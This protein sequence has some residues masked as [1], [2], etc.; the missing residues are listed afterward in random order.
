M[1][2][3]V[4]R[5]SARQRSAAGVDGAGVHDERRDRSRRAVRRSGRSA[6]V[7]AVRID[8]ALE[9][10]RR[11]AI[12]A[13]A[14][15]RSARSPIGSNQAISSATVVVVVGDLGVG[16]AHHPGDADR[17]I[18]G[19][20]DQQVVGGSVRSTPSSVVIG[21]PS[22]RQADAEA[23]AAERGQVVGVVRLA[24]LEHHVVADVDD[25]VD[26]AHAGG[27]QAAR[28]PRRGD[29]PTATPDMTVRREAA[30]AVAVDDLDGERSVVAG[31]RGA[32]A[33]GRE[34][35]RRAGRRGRGRRRRSPSSRGGCG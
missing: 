35:R 12:A 20:A 3:S 33:G 30:A 8:A 28:H 13:R 9:A 34:L 14:A 31:R 11:L 27:G 16:A 25:V 5:C 18:V 26:R 2:T 15:P 7:D 21:S 10:G 24:E 1:R 32:G 19:V 29:G 17:A 23:A 22:P 6:S 4:A